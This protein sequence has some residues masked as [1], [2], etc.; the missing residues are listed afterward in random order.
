MSKLVNAN[1]SKPNIS[2]NV[3]DTDFLLK[4]I[5]RSSF[6]GNEI[7]IAH[8]VLSKLAELHRGNVEG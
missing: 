6:E 2:F 5:M 3:K 7:E 4:L 8:S 1:N